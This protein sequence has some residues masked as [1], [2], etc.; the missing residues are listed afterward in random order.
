MASW[1]VVIYFIVGV[2]LT[3]VISTWWKERKYLHAFP[4]I[5]MF[6]G[7]LLSNLKN[8][9]D[10]TFDAVLALIGGGASMHFIVLVEKWAQ[11]KQK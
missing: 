5:Y 4:Y 7:M 6:F 2:V 3:D 8:S 1:V 11:K 9:I 10:L